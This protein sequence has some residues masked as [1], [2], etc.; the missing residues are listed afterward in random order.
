MANKYYELG[1]TDPLRYYLSYEDNKYHCIKCGHISPDLRGMASHIRAEDGVHVECPFCGLKVLT[2]GIGPHVKNCS[3]NPL[4]QILT[5]EVMEKALELPSTI[6]PEIVTIKLDEP[7][8]GEKVAKT[9]KKRCPFCGKYYSPHGI[10]LHKHH[11]VKNPKK[12]TK[13]I[14]GIMSREWD[15]SVHTPEDA[16]HIKDIVQRVHEKGHG[17]VG[18]GEYAFL[19]LMKEKEEQAWKDA[20]HPVLG[21]P[22]PVKAIRAEKVEKFIPVLKGVDYKLE[23]GVLTI[24]TADKAM[25]VKLLE[26][27]L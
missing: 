14:R 10:G 26:M 16:A 21:P 9:T 4:N 25:I 13:P 20:A 17:V 1:T 18:G 27:V 8:G 19:R 5:D 7:T 11:C 22:K 23:N 12:T 24:T 3:K 2:H 15:W 6:E